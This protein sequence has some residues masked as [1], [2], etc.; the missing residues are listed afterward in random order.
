MENAIKAHNIFKKAYAKIQ[1]IGVSDEDI[2]AGLMV[3]V[4]K[5]LTNMYGNDG[6]AIWFRKAAIQME[7]EV[8]NNFH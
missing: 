1:E 4:M 5:E 2:R 6:A 3:F 7:Q 8:K